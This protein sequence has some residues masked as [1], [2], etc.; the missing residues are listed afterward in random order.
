MKCGAIPAKTASK[1][2]LVRLWNIELGSMGER[3]VT[4]ALPDHRD[5]EHVPVHIK[6]DASILY[7]YINTNM[8]S[9]V[10]EDITSTKTGNVTSLNLYVMDSVTGHVLHQSVSPVVQ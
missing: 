10:S 3:I 2:Q 9:V 7:K 1:H 5:W 4:A 8:L 6:G